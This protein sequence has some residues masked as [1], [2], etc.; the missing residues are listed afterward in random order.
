M[1]TELLHDDALW[2]KF[3]EIA[4]LTTEQL[5][6]FKIFY[7]MLKT[8]NEMHNLTAKTDLDFVI[9]YHFLDSLALDNAQ[10]MQELTCIADIGTGG[11]FP[12]LPLKIK[13]PHLKVVLIEVTNK[14]IWFLESVIKAL[15]LTDVEIY[16]QDWRTFLRK[17]DYPIELFCSRASLQPSELI[18]AFKP[19]CLYK[20]STIVYWASQDWEPEH[21]IEPYI[22]NKSLY[23][24]GSKKRFLVFLANEK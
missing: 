15:N 4:A 5:D 11:G 16:D 17:T 8:A 18:R 1:K 10:N 2:V 21:E 7:E 23:K 14:K 22:I 24:V 3:A 6:K 12:G 13:Y 19:S 20:D 9:N